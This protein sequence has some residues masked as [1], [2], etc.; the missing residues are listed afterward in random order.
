MSGPD[1]RPGG[2]AGTRE[3]S[4]LTSR[5]RQPAAGPS[6]RATRSAA[7]PSHRG[8][9]SAASR[10]QLVLV[11]AGVI[12]VALVPVVL[13]YLQLGYAADVEASEG[14]TDPGWNA[15]RLLERAVHDA[16][17]GVP[18]EYRWGRRRA[19]VRA[20][21][22][23]LAGPFDALRTAR[24]ADGTAYLVRYNESAASAWAAAN[25]PSGP[26]RRFGPCE[27]RDGVAVQQRAGETHVLAVAVDVTVVTERGST[28][29]TFVVR[30]VGGAVG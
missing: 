23:R 4:A 15:K 25:C 11:A 18:G 9:R 2:A 3:A 30:P 16:A 28:E 8:D 22:D 10:G 1:R 17:A 27:A 14:Y 12:A 19:A 20:V 5:G 6:R 24:L 29:L 26:A 21:H 13:A 7:G